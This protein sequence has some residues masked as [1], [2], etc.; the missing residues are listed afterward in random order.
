[1]ISVTGIS[2]LHETSAQLKRLKD[3]DLGSQSL[4][5]YFAITKKNYIYSPEMYSNAIHLAM[6]VKVAEVVNEVKQHL[7]VILTCRRLELVANFEYYSHDSDDRQMSFLLNSSLP[8]VAL[9]K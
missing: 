8:G 7:F 4:I 3:V 9:A 2:L 1:M 5:Q 6:S